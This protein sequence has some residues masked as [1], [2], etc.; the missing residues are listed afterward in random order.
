VTGPRESPRPGALILISDRERGREACERASRPFGPA[1]PQ[2]FQDGPLTVALEPDRHRD[3]HVSERIVCLLEGGLYDL[4]ASVSPAQHLATAYQHQ[5][6]T[7]LSELRGEFW[8]LLWDRAGMRGIVVS[9]QLGTHAPYWAREGATTIVAS[10][11]PELIAALSRQPDPD[12]VELAH[13]LMIT[14]PRAGRTLL[15]GVQSVR[16]GHKLSLTASH[17]VAERYWGPEY[18]EPFRASADDQAGRLR[19]AHGTAVSR[20]CTGDTSGLLLSGGLDSSAVAGF[21][22]ESGPVSGYSAVFPDHP[23]MDESPLIDRITARLGIGSTRIVVR[24]GSTIAGALAYLRAWRVPPT[25]PNLFFWTPL[26][27]RAADDGIEVMLDGEGGDELFGFSPYLVSDRLRRGRLLGALRLTRSW[28]AQARPPSRELLWIRLRDAGLAPMLP[29]SAHRLS[30]RL[31]GLDSYAPGWLPRPLARSWLDSEDSGFAFKQ[32][33]GPRW[34][35]Y[36]TYLVTRGAGPS[37]VYEQAR[38]RCRL[39]GIEPRHPL[40]D[41]DVIDTALR[42]DP[43]LAFDPRF[44]RAMLREAIDDLVPDQVRLRRGK[45]NFDALFHQ[46]LAGPELPAVRQLLDPTHAELRAYV[47]MAG[48]YRELLEA[49]PPSRAGGLM[50]WAIRVWRLVTAECW[51]RSRQQGSPAFDRLESRLRLPS[52]GFTIETA[53][54]LE[55]G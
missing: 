52:P 15:A 44:N 6:D 16:A 33:P 49:A 35:A 34:W 30:R 13:W 10:E 12:P 48:L 11:V 40:V 18:R 43:A 20:R 24:G 37:A 2:V 14:G 46:L 55:G 7:L 1:D 47:D 38:R 4:P 5:G 41:V 39:A 54:Q 17:A 19:H 26:L 50:D 36:V 31:R 28:P 23:E 9:D 45:S 22:V 51:L 27:H 25:S 29:P 53:N 42:M 3:L 8:A 21:A 32:L